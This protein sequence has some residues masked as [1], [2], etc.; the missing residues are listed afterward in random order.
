MFKSDLISHLQP[1]GFEPGSDLNDVFDMVLR[2]TFDFPQSTA[3]FATRPFTSSSDDDEDLDSPP[4]SPFFDLKRPFIKEEPEDA[5]SSSGASSPLTLSRDELLKFSSETLESLAQN[6]ASS[7]PLTDEERKQLKK[8]KRLI[9]NR[10]SAQL[11]RQRKKYYLEELEKKVNGVNVENQNLLKRLS[12]LEEENRALRQA[13]QLA[14][15]A[16]ISRPSGGENSSGT[17]RK[18]GATLTHSSRQFKVPKLGIKA[19]GVYLLVVLLSF[20]LFLNMK[21]DH[22]LLR[23]QR[24]E[25]QEQAEKDQLLALPSF[26]SSSILAESF[27]PSSSSFG[28]S[29]PLSALSSESDSPVALSPMVEGGEGSRK[30]GRGEET[31]PEMDGIAKSLRPSFSDP[32]DP[33]LSST[34]S[35]HEEEE[36]R[37]QLRD[38]QGER[39]AITATVIMSEP[40]VLSLF[41]SHP[42]NITF[43]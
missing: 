42:P 18:A 9:K 21:K 33:S 34:P 38:T 13:N 2:E 29:A 36:S 30:R 32:E 5:N 31:D 11:S 3:N 24:V 19:T 35:S 22:N 10:E 17:Q 25:R 40:N 41:V 14:R 20:G 12:E 28:S 37:D 16:S 39:E 43:M 26:C 23:A 7:R 15:V 4:S 1:I 6:L 27:F 8:Q